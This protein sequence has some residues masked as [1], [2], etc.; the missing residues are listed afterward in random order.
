MKVLV[1]GDGL[2][3]SE[4]INQTG[5]DCISRKKDNFDI[6]CLDIIPNGYDVIV[7][8]IANTNTYSDDKDSHWET[9]YVFV[10]DL[11]DYC[12][13]RYIKLVHISTDY[14]YAGS[15]SYASE[16]SIPLHCDNWYGYTKLLSDGIV[17]LRSNNYLLCRCTQVPKPFPYDKGWT[18][19]IGNLDYV[20]VISD[21]IIK[22][23]NND[24]NGIFN[25]GTEV[26]TTYE[27]AKQ[28]KPNV[29]KSL[30]PNHVPGDLSMD[31]SKLK[32]ELKEP[33]FSIA[34][35]T[36]EMEGVGVSFLNHNLEML[37]EQTFKDF[38]VVVSDHSSD[39]KIKLLCYQWGD[40]LN[41]RYYKNDNGIGKSSANINNSLK[42]CNG[43]WVKIVFQDDF[44]Y[45]NKSLQTIYD[46]IVVNDR[47]K[48]IVTACEHTN[49]GITMFRPFYP[50]WN[51]KMH[52]GINTFSSPSVLTFKNENILYFDER[53]VNLMDVDYYKRMYDIYGEPHY[54]T[55]ITVVN[56]VWEGSV[57]NTLSNEI[58]Q[59]ELQLM[60]GKYS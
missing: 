22:L 4:I 47:I 30:K 20:D 37:K 26:K 29:G 12:N 40:R 23:I 44:L 8:C 35:P 53:L 16:D 38:E 1:L 21:L 17:Q 10:N 14:V 56:R 5:W 49:D 3:G 46:N 58:K 39:D 33:F 25:V 6:K 36:Y 60:I 54:I 57:T 48:W 55:T 9:N 59:K 34:I 45:S 43:R 28:T 27:L 42:Y 7:N 31:I 11:I 24:S 52:L 2:L 13:E 51:H 32:K 41:I 18:D 15:K 50:K 19:R